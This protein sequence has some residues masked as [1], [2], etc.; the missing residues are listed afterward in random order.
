MSRGW[1]VYNDAADKPTA[2]IIDEFDPYDD[3]GLVPTDGLELYEDA[4]Y[5]ITL[6]LTMDNL[7]DGANYAFF[8]GNHLHEAESPNG[9]QRVDHRQPLGLPVRSGSQGHRAGAPF[10]NFVIRFKADNP[11]VWLFHCHIEWHM[12]SGLAA[13]MIEAPLELQRT[14][15]ISDNHYQVCNAGNTLTSGNAA[16]NTVDFYDLSGENKSKAPLP[17]G[18]TARGIVALVFSCTAG[19]VGMGA[20]AWYGA[21]PITN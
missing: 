15:Q 12:D 1:L 18:F 4:D 5:T 2:A 14:L 10:G 17:A 11:G 13:T 20:I 16:G 8:N 6:D 9:F 3:F 19:F 21:A 7:G